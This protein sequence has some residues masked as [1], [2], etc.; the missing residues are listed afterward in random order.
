MQLDKSMKGAMA[1]H[2][3]VEL[4]KVRTKIEESSRDCGNIETRKKKKVDKAE[5]SGVEMN[6]SQG[7]HLQAR[8]LQEKDNG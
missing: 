8:K 7:Q 3:Q 2:V 1:E 6:L 5:D 4:E